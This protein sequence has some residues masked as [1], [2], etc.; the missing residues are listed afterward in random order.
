MVYKFVMQSFLTF[1][2]FSHK[3]DD[4]L[5]RRTLL[6]VSISDVREKETCKHKYQA[7]GQCWPYLY[8]RCVN[9]ATGR[10]GVGT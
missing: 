3:T 2:T 10:D 4:N 9:E 6:T 1:L 8:T 5:R 7:G